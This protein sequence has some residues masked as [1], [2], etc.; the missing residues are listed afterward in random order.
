M[1]N[2]QLEKLAAMM[3]KS[4][5][6]TAFV[7]RSATP[8]GL[9]LLAK[10]R[11]QQVRRSRWLHRLLTALGFIL[12]LLVILSFVALGWGFHFACPAC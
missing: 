8:V 10:Y 4:P 12:A 3:D 9:R 5:A 7:E 2:P 11:E 6:F 1:T